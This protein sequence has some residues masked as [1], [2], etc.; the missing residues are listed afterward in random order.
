M[1]FY[2]RYCR[3]VCMINDN[4]KNN[5]YDE[6]FKKQ[7]NNGN[8]ANWLRDYP[9]VS[10]E[11]N[12]ID[13]LM[14]TD[15]KT[16]LANDL[17]VKMDIASMANALETRSPFLDHKLMEFAAKLPAEY[18]MKMLIKKIR[19]SPWYNF[20]SQTPL[21]RKN[22]Y[23]YNPIRRKRQDTMWFNLEIFPFFIP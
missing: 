4:E 8:P 19:N 2:L 7:L 3:W 15:I 1:P 9:C 20:H 11:M 23:T 22:L 18:K 5:L 14:A 21:F 10:N 13:L 17:L 6:N 12:L 16:N